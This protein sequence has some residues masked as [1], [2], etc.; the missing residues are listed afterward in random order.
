MGNGETMNIKQQTK[1]FAKHAK[2]EN[3]QIEKITKLNP[4]FRKV[5]GELITIIGRC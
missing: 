3:K 4:S 1:I 5:K 2:I